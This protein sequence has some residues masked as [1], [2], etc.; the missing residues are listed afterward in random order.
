MRFAQAAWHGSSIAKIATIVDRLVFTMQ[1]AINA[2]SSRPMDATSSR[3]MD[4]ELSQPM[5]ANARDN[6]LLQLTADVA[7]VKLQFS[8]STTPVPQTTSPSDRPPKFNRFNNS[9]HQLSSLSLRDGYTAICFYYR[10]LA[11]PHANAWSAARGGGIPR[12][13]AVTAADYMGQLPH[14][15]TPS[16]PTLCRCTDTLKNCRYNRDNVSTS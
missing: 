7:E 1:S 3:L 16:L 5:Y 13:P 2:A 9:Y 11:P 10:R 12:G 8:F 14:R 6:L 4:A 15:S